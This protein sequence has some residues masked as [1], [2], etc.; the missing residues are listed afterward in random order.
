[1]FEYF[2]DNY[3]WNMG[4]LMASQMG[5]IMSEIDSVCR[6]LRAIGNRPEARTD[7]AA[8]DAWIGAW[9][10]L[11]ERIEGLARLDEEAGHG[12]SAGRKRLRAALYYM[13]AERFAPH[14]DPRKLEIY[15]RMLAAFRA[16]AT[17]R[18]DPVEW[19][20]IPYEGK[21][22]PSLFVPPPASVAGD[23]PY[24]C[25][26]HFDGFDVTKEWTYLSGMVEALAARGVASLIVDHP[27]VGGAIRYHGL[28]TVVDTERPAGA[29]LDWLADRPEVDAG[30]VGIVA[31]S[32]GGY[33]APRAAAFDPRLACC[34]AWG[35]RWDNAGSHGRIL[36]D[37]T[38]ARS[39]PGWLEH[40]KWYYGRDTE[41]GCAEVIDRMTLEGIADRIRCPILVAHGSNDRQVPLE[42]AQRTIDEAVNSPRRDLK[43][44]TEE[45][46]G[47]EHVGVD[48]LSIQIDYMTDWIADVLG[49]DAAGG[50]KEAGASARVAA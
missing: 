21:A 42:Q 28:P 40:A 41:E 15:E 17:L 20:D 24:P 34:V 39:V 1:M 13:Q 29:C 4:V 12:L 37:P 6:P 43:I 36:R 33:Y 48:N 19:V 27:G 31:M 18:A 46:G 26:I 50:L 9:T 38:A 45:E 32:L 10:E 47:I 8:L 16:G 2:D 49:G 5:G 35:A 11:G 25:M 30:S 7:P 3:S 14:T 44:F 23:G 22:L